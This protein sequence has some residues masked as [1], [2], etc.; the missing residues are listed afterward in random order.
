MK[1]WK[2]P[3]CKRSK[4]TPNQIIISLCKCGEYF[5]ESGV[6]KNE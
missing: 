6:E 5:K 2:C 1:E 4:T 3:N